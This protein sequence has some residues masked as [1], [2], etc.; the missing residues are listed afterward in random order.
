MSLKSP[1]VH[2]CIQLDQAFLN[3]FCLLQKWTSWSLSTSNSQ[4]VPVSSRSVWEKRSLWAESPQQRSFL[5][6]GRHSMKS[7][8]LLCLLHL[9]NFSFPCL[10]PLTKGPHRQSTS[11]PWQHVVYGLCQ[12][13]HGSKSGSQEEKQWF[14]HTLWCSSFLDRGLSA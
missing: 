8:S 3:S 7:P 5:P 12:L 11:I 2:D 9:R 4:K 14:Y 10:P 13:R 1:I 6:W